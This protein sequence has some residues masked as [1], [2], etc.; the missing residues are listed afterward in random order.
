MHVFV[1]E[2]VSSG[3]GGGSAPASLRRE[4][5]AMLD[6]VLHDLGRCSGVHTTTLLDGEGPR[7][8]LPWPNHETVFVSSGEEAARFREEARRADFTLVI[9]PEFDDL[10]LT[11]CRWVNE[12][13]GR[14]LGSDLDAV[15]L[16]SDKLLLS[17]HFRNRSVPTPLTS[18][19][20]WTEPIA[21]YPSVVKPRYGA[22]SQATFL[23]R[24]SDDCAALSECWPG[25]MIVQ[26]YCPGFAASI[27]FLL[28]RSTRV[29]LPAAAQEL[30]TDGRFSYLGG[31]LPLTSDLTARAR[32]LGDQAIEAVD[33]LFGYV[34][35]DIVLGAASDGRDDVVI[36]INPRLTTSYLGLRRLAR[37]NLADALLAV[38]AG[39]AV[40]VLDW[41]ETSIHFGSS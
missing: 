28:G 21:A 7:P 26:P 40:A 22:G 37:F 15:R 24:N 10:L 29:A 38:A 23:L 30:S 4:G 18:P 27:A 41:E 16:T 36:E 5:W 34:G 20:R 8:A 13:G 17:E 6:A 19:W 35:V 33:G 25:E 2:F 3:Y 32:R 31:H 1:Y 12:C 39:S 11:R 14:L 9:A